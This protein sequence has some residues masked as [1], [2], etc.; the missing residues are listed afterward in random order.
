[1]W[2]IRVVDSTR[3][4]LIGSTYSGVAWISGGMVTPMIGWRRG[5]AYSSK[6]SD[7]V[8][9]RACHSNNFMV[10]AV[11]SQGTTASWGGEVSTWADCISE[12][13][14]FAIREHIGF[15]S[16]GPLNNSLRMANMQ[17]STYG[18]KIRKDEGGRMVVV[19]GQYPAA[20]G[21]PTVIH[22]GGELY[23][24]G[25]GADGPIEIGENIV[26]YDATGGRAPAM[27]PV[28]TAAA[29]Q[30]YAALGAL[31][32]G[33]AGITQMRTRR[34][35]V[36]ARQPGGTETRMFRVA[37]DHVEIAGIRYYAGNGPPENRVTAP[38]ASYYT[39]RD[40]SLANGI[41]WVKAQ[42][43]GPTGWVRLT[44]TAAP[45]VLD[46][47][48]EA[49]A[50]YAEG[51]V[52]VIAPGLLHP[53]GTFTRTH[54]SGARALSCD[55]LGTWSYVAANVPRFIGA[56]QRWLREPATANKSPNVL[57]IGSPPTTWQVSFPGGVNATYTPL[58]VRGLEGVLVEFTGEATGTVGIIVNGAGGSTGAGATAAAEGEVF[59]GAAFAQ[60]RSDPL[61]P[62][63][64]SASCGVQ[65]L[66]SGGSTPSWFSTRGDFGYR[67]SAAATMP[68]GTTACRWRM[69]FAGPDAGETVNFAL[70]IGPHK[71][72][73]E[74]SCT[75]PVV[76]AAG[77]SG[78]VS[79]GGDGFVMPAS[80]L[81]V[82]SNG[83]CSGRM[84]FVTM[85][86][87]PAGA[88]DELIRVGP[89][90]NC[91]MIY[92]AAGTSSLRARRVIGGTPG[93]ELVVETLTVGTP[94]IDP[95]VDVTG[96][97]EITWTFA[98]DGTISVGVVAAGKTMQ[99]QAGTAISGVTDVTVARTA[100]VEVGPLKIRDGVPA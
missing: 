42:G 39:Q 18:V 70:W 12:G 98:A 66:P 53:D 21:L 97:T 93:A 7:G 10:F 68:S 58:T 86:A 24:T 3:I 13:R 55:A 69:S 46:A 81:G 95:A 90:T 27:T 64:T 71:I 49:A 11:V 100:H 37:A 31:R 94:S 79:H 14:G 28:G 84:G 2:Q 96:Y 19:G 47:A 41:V 85:R 9:W 54:S 89:A 62:I 40:G 23:L 87:A 51:G 65:G 50:T 61:D 45:L 17:L 20:S 83:A 5:I 59:F 78:T 63:I 48:V 32:G 80:S 57:A 22:N 4:D 1:M 15:W 92:L 8:S 56:E 82:G 67:R 26:A 30:K 36:L 25:V 99:T 60:E 33:A 74:L 43:S 88:D 73:E 72:S 77:A 76:P 52:S 6:G 29:L 38:K 44:G 91:Y 35:D 34:L 75:L 16:A